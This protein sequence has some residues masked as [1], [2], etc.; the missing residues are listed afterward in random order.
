MSAP[1]AMKQ[2]VFTGF[3][4]PAAGFD[5][6]FEMLAA[7]HERGVLVIGC[8][9]HA[10]VIRVLCPLNIEQ[11]VLDGALGVICEEVERRT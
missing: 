3:S 9:V 10:N 5:Q 1:N 11:D 2:P 8:G 4:S 6:P 7:C